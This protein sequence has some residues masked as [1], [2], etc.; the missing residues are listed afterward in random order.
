VFIIIYPHGDA[1]LYVV[2]ARTLFS[3]G[4]RRNDRIAE[5]SRN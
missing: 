5:L 1:A 3:H 2:Y 4:R